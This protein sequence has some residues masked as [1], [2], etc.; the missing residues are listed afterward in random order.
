MNGPL[1]RRR[2]RRRGTGKSWPSGLGRPSTPSAGP[3]RSRGDGDNAIRPRRSAAT[4]PPART[5]S[6]RR[7]SPSRAAAAEGR[8]APAETP[9]VGSPRPSRPGHGRDPAT[10]GGFH[11][12]PW[13]GSG[14]A[15]PIAR[16]RSTAAASR[17]PTSTGPGCRRAGRAIAPRPGRPPPRSAPRASAPG[18]PSARVRRSR[19]TRP[20]IPPRPGRRDTRAP[21]TGPSPAH[22]AAASTIRRT[23]RP[24]RGSLDRCGRRPAA[25]SAGRGRS[26]CDGGGRSGWRSARAGPS[27]APVSCASTAL[28]SSTPRA[29]MSGSP[30]WR[31][32]RGQPRKPRRGTSRMPALKSIVIR[33]SSN[34]PA[35]QLAPQRRRAAR[36][37]PGPPTASKAWPCG[38]ACSTEKNRNACE[39][40]NSTMNT[41]AISS[42]TPASNGRTMPAA[43]AAIPSTNS[44]PTQAEESRESHGHPGGRRPLERRRPAGV[45]PFH[46]PHQV[47]EVL[48]GH[49]F[50]VFGGFRRVR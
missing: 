1:P 40:A 29:S 37:R 4:G 7:S 47:V 48:A 44:S 22:G 13:C 26:R 16:R 49:R 46:P 15:P 38:G 8:G 31:I 9:P 32:D 27:R 43:N 25:A 17:R 6:R 36:A 14:R 42:Q 28:S 35:L 11:R 2:R 34:G 12:C 39:V 45:P 41:P 24:P 10:P 3:R 50:A 21:G 23:A 5:R 33:T 30:I 19:R 20:R 18:I